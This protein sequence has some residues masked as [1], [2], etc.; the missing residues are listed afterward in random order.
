MVT[1]GSANGPRRWP[2][3]LAWTAAALAVG[4]LAGV[5]TPLLNR[6]A[7]LSV[8]AAGAVVAA[9]AVALAG[10]G[11]GLWARW[12]RARTLP[13]W[14]RSARSM[15]VPQAVAEVREVAP[16]LELMRQ[17]LD[18]ALQES[19]TSALQTIERM[20]AIHLVSNA[21]TDRIR[22]TEVNGQE[23]ERLMKEKAMVDTQL[24][25]ILQMFVEKQEHEVD[26]NLERMQRLQEVRSLSPLVDVIAN[27]A[28]QTNFLSI[29]AAIEA[30]RAGE[31]GRGFAVVAAEIRQLSNRTATV[32]VDIAA[33]IERVTHG[34]DRELEQVSANQDRSSSS[35]NMRR[36]LADI[37]DMQR[38]SAE[39]LAT[40]QLPR[41]IE[42]VKQGHQ[43]IQMRLADTLGQMQAQDVMRQRVEG[44]QQSMSELDAHL[45]GVAEQLQDQ[46]W[47]P[48][49]MST[50]KDRLKEGAERYVMQ[51]QRRT[52]QAVTGQALADTVDAPLIELF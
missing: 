4:L 8:G 23:L 22:S 43:D 16:Y 32:A 49:R 42:D 39:S 30:A 14:L 12:S 17:H 29:T 31:S 27:V 41:V 7:G 35:S 51:S 45:Q 37:A 52:H 47:D 2:Q 9:A 21:Q 13:A 50:L 33:K 18:G 28:R 48:D 36:V 20:N 10:V 11:G 34:I 6:D 26:A 24:G 44:V 38:R 46:A 5:I 19:E 3:T 1:Q 25:S 15:P 40:L